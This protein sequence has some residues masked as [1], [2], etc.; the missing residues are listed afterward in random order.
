MPMIKK[1]FATLTLLALSLPGL[2]FAQ[3]TYND[4]TLDS[5][6]VLSVGGITVNVAA[7]GATLNTLTVNASDFSVILGPGSSIAVTAPDLNQLAS[8]AGIGYLVNQT[9]TDVVSKISL[10]ASGSAATTTVTVTPSATLCAAPSASSS[11]GG[12]GGNGPPISSGGGGGAPAAAPTI[13]PTGTAAVIA[14]LQAQVQ[15]LIAQL[16]AFT[17]GSVGAL[18]GFSRNL[19]VGSTGAEVKALQVYLNTHGYT[20]ASSGAA[21]SPGNETTRFGAATRAALIKLQKAAGI[22]PAAGYFGPKT[23]AYINAHP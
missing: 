22:T 14:S 10:Q 9:C 3:G 18:G 6:V 12:G 1:L 19:E 2:A 23:R 11:G 4:V 8:D 15:A 16:A 17:G 20:V 7:A 5:N 21:G 13:T